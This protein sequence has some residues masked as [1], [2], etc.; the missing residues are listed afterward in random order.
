MAT[1]IL[2][3]ERLKFLLTYDLPSG[4]FIRNTNT[5]GKRAGA[6]A[7][8]V[9]VN[10]YRY[11]CV[12]GQYHLAHRLAWFYVHGVWPEGA[13]DHINRKRSDNRLVNL[14]QASSKENGENY[15]LFST[16]T[17]G[18]R[19]VQWDPERHLWSAQ[20]K[21]H[22]KS[23]YLGRFRTKLEA[24]AARRGA[25]RVAYTHSEENVEDEDFSPT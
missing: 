25:E 11:V 8:T 6:I 21:H 15:G 14:R 18:F 19:G 13:L 7:G 17:S 5:G 9:G 16:N 2:Q 12:D 10:G 4:E 24:I 3:L 22:G 1:P 20:I 23:I